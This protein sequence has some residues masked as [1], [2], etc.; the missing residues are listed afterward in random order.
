MRVGIIVY[1]ETGNT[2]M[3]AM[4]IK[5]KLLA[6]GH[7]TEL[8]RLET[9]GEYKSGAKEVQLESIPEVDEYDWVMFGSPVHGF[10]L[11]LPMRTFLSQIGSLENKKVAC[12]ATQFCFFPGWA[13]RIPFQK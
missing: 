12:F 5:D 7:L 1:S 2:Y 3:L 13:A 9:I 10:T 11:S 8:K 6:S 4:K